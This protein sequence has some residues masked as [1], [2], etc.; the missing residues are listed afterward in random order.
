MRQPGEVTTT[1]C[2]RRKPANGLRSTEQLICAWCATGST[3]L[4]RQPCVANLT[5]TAGPASES[6]CQQPRPGGCVK[7]PARTAMRKVIVGSRL[8]S[9]QHPQEGLHV[10]S[11]HRR[12]P[13]E[14]QPP[15][16]PPWC[17]QQPGCSGVGNDAG[18]GARATIIKND[19]TPATTR[20][21]M[22]HP[23]IGK[24]TGR[25]QQLARGGGGVRVRERRQ[26]R[27]CKGRAWTATV[28][29]PFPRSSWAVMVLHS[30]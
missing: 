21:T 19:N 12:V 20:P 8:L 24:R 4:L 16:T 13:P 22:R 23:R 2:T 30:R 14:Q 11:L 27:C 15:A 9:S 1:A 28:E 6:Q 29:Y 10:P 17:E 5:C 26:L 18:L 3:T 7:A 25:A